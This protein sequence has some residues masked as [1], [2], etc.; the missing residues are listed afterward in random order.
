MWWE[1]AQV[2]YE[3][4]KG[5]VGDVME[6]R[7]RF[8]TKRTE[9]DRDVFDPFYTEI[10]LSQGELQGVLDGLVSRMQQERE[11]EGMLNEQERTF[12]ESL[13]VEKKTVEKMRTDVKSIN[14]VDYAIDDAIQ[15]LMEQINLARGYE[16]QAWQNLK[17]IGKEL[18]DKK[19]RELYFGMDTIGKNI[20]AIHEYIKGPFSQH[21]DML[22]STAEEK[23]SSVKSAAQSLK[24]KGLDLKK[25]V[26]QLTK[27]EEKVEEAPPPKPEVE[28]IKPEPKGWFATISSY[29]TTAFSWVHA[30]LVKVS[31]WLMSSMD[32]VLHLFGRK[33][34]EP[35]PAEAVPA[36]AAP[37]PAPEPEEAV[38]EEVVAEEVSEEEPAEEAPAEMEEEAEEPEAGEEE[39]PAEEVSE[40]EMMEEEPAEEEEMPAEEEAEESTAEMGAGEKVIEEGAAEE[41]VVEESAEDKE[42]SVEK[43]E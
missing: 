41:E 33:P 9:L 19:A 28:K 38:E 43:K 2:K 10:G 42:R 37:T 27:D 5:F 39:V 16:K 30:G 14:K 17:S 7:M 40:E 1:K 36:E 11:E 31:G 21:F 3:R 32:Y 34:P 22:A 13:H 12:L 23:T 24:E 25:Q 15:K 26:E 4:I 29:G 6:S 20:Q 8:F 35:V 18:S